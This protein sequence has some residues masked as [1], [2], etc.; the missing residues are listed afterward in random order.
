M[1]DDKSWE[2][3]QTA[4]WGRSMGDDQLWGLLRFEILDDITVQDLKGDPPVPRIDWLHKE[5][6]NCSRDP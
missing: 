5:M 6:V 1:K 3:W 4:V 2:S